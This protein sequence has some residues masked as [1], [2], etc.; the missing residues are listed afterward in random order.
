MIAVDFSGA[1]P[2]IVTLKNAGVVAV[3]RYLTGSGKAISAVELQSY[4]DAGIV[5][6]FVFEV[7]AND[8]AGGFA[9]GAAHAQQAIAALAA[10]GIT[11]CPIYFACDEDVVA[12]A[13]VPYFRGVNSVLSAALTGVYGEGSLL[14]LLNADGLTTFHWLS[15]STGFPGY[16]QALDSGIVNL[17][18]KFNMSPVPGTDVDLILKPDIGQWPRPV[19]PAP[20]PAPS[21]PPEEADDMITELVSFN[22]S[23][24]QVQR[25]ASGNIWH[26]WRG[27]GATKFESEPLPYAGGFVGNP[28]LYVDSGVTPPVL[29]VECEEAPSTENLMVATQAAGKSW[30]AWT[31]KA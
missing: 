11:G 30:S 25:N 23:T 24:H 10:L 5:V 20:T 27:V 13:A 31:A 7:G 9:A 22:G 28:I 3:I 18:Q 17:Q 1:R 29:T 2:T 12:S 6:V 26:F 16:Q 14:I 19:P 15:E 8:V 21:P 4:L